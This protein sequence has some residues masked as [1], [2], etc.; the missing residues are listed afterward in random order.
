[1]DM[2]DEA[3]TIL[4]QLV[5]VDGDPDRAGV[6]DDLVAAV[7]DALQ[8]SWEAAVADLGSEWAEVEPDDLWDDAARAEILP[9]WTEIADGL[10]QAHLAAHRGAGDEVRRACQM[11]GRAL[12]GDVAVQ[13]NSEFVAASGTDEVRARQLRDW[14]VS[15]HWWVTLTDPDGES[16]IYRSGDL[17]SWPALLAEARERQAAWEARERADRERRRVRV[18]MA[19]GARRD[20]ERALAQ[21][22]AELDEAWAEWDE[23]AAEQSVPAVMSAA[24]I[25]CYRDWLGVTMEWLAARLGVA[26]R[27]VRRWEAETTAVPAGV[28]AEVRQLVAV[29]DQQ[30][31]VM[32]DAVP[33]DD[34]VVVTYRGDED[35]WAA[36]GSRW[37]GSWHRALCGRLADRVPGLRIV[38]RGAAR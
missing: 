29:A 12:V 20:A 37:P 21:A 6:P 18:Q 28:A 22:Q 3:R 36:D 11:Q 26:E 8:E 34:P 14:P 38:Y 2:M 33:A 5:D 4:A 27:T 13:P 19:T 23:P 16:D 10:W 35:H 17:V 1:M 32:L 24:E 31:A 9:E 25:R 30:L 15:P 7:A